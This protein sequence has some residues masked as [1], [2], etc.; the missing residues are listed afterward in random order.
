M[1]A[2]T[3]KNRFA[4]AALLLSM[5]TLC[6][7]GTAQLA[8]A[9]EAHAATTAAKP[10]EVL[11]AGIPIEFFIFGA[12]L[13]GV[14]MFHH[15]TLQVASTGLLVLTLT[16]LGFGLGIGH[17]HMT[18]FEGL[19]HH[20]GVEWVTIVNLGCLLLGFELLSSHFKDSKVPDRLPDYL[21]DGYWGAASLLLLVFVMSAFLDNIA[22]A[23][24]GGSIASTVFKG[25]VHIGYLAAIVAASNAG[26]AGSVVGD[27]TTTMMWIDGINPLN[28][29]EAF[30]AASIA[31]VISGT[32]GS[33]Q[34]TKLRPIQ[35]EATAE[36]KID[37]G[38]LG[39]VFAIL[40]SAIAANVIS[41]SYYV[42]YAEAAP[43]LGMAVWGAILLTAPYKRP[44][45]EGLPHAAQGA[46]FLLSLVLSASMMPVESLPTAAPG[47]AMGLG[48]VSSVFDNIPLTKLALA[49]GGYDWGFLAFAVGFGGSMI[50]FGSSAGVAITNEFPEG[51]S[52]VNWLKHGWHVIL[53]YTIAFPIMW[54]IVGWHPDPPHKKTAVSPTHAATEVHAATHHE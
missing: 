26:G 44:H 37:W 21:P 42:E 51:R 27:T 11:I 22:A 33:W 32:V 7:M 18:G 35:R 50:W 43:W 40:V 23:M 46:L 2:T 31:L 49:Q 25:K 29:I 47:V 20:L 39:V 9:D 34:Q 53:A 17:S 30:I 48:Y 41:N 3:F 1:W 15:Y 5:A 10:N 36:V 13:F 6:W 14:A 19:G 45:W 52:V 38:R 12:T 8:L 16:K 28:V 54:A 4:K 24:I